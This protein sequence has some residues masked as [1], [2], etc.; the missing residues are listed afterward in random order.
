MADVE[1]HNDSADAADAFALFGALLQ[2]RMQPQIPGVMA[3]TM[4]LRP[5]IFAGLSAAS[6]AIFF[7]GVLPASVK[8]MIIMTISIQNDC[9]FCANLHSAMLEQLG[10]PEAVIASCAGDP[11]LAQVPPLYRQI[12]Q[13]S[14]KASQTPTL[15]ADEDFQIL[16]DS[17]L[18]DDEILEVAMVAAYSNFLNIWTDIP[19]VLPH[20]ER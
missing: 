15:V 16:R 5:D 4:R 14:L 11:G 17:G 1:P 10:V 6:E 18:T 12:L 3:L 2:G 7:E 19:D 13:F 20:Q 8:Q 9:R